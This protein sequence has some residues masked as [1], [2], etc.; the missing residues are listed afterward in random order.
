MQ[1]MLMLKTDPKVRTVPTPELMHAKVL[2]PAHEME[3]EVRQMFP[4]GTSQRG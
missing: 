3:S 4:V 2:G 1:F